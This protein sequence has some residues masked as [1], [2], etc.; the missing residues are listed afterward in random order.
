M[1]AGGAIFNAGGTL[2]VT[3]TL[4]I[5]GGSVAGGSSGGRGLW[6]GIF[7]GRADHGD[8]TQQPTLTFAPLAGQTQRI[9]DTI[10]DESLIP[11]GIPFSGTGITVSGAGTVILTAQCWYSSNVAVQSGTL[12]LEAGNAGANTLTVA[13]G[14]TLTGQGSVNKLVLLSGAQFVQGPAIVSFSTGDVTWNGG[15]TL[16]AALSSS[17]ATATSLAIAGALAKGE[18]GQFV[19]DFKGT[20]QGGRTYTL[21]TFRSTTFA[22]SDFSAANLPAGLTGTFVVTPTQLQIQL[23]NTSVA[24]PRAAERDR[25]RNSGDTPLLSNRRHKFAVRLFGRQRHAASR[26]HLEHLDRAHF[27]N[28]D[29]HGRLH[30]GG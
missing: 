5:S 13:S 24:V 12:D 3:G 7:M 14:A 10:G 2:T 8:S 6:E 25:G 29:H 19:I 20:G 17:D 16:S 27:W 11:Y 30:G 4:S 18:A 23:L 28:A 26:P 21:A 22:A 1:G 15:A 9:S